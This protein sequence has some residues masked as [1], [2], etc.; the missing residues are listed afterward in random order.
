MK[1]YKIFYYA[2][3]DVGVDDIFIAETKLQAAKKFIIENK[4]MYNVAF[5]T[6]FMQPDKDTIE[7]VN[8]LLNRV[9]QTNVEIVK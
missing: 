8:D 1:A 3:T 6:E 9:L 7:S 4:G 5:V 2:P